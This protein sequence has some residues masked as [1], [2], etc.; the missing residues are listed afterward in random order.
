MEGKRVKTVLKILVVG[1]LVLFAGWFLSLRRSVDKDLRLPADTRVILVSQTQSSGYDLLTI[2]YSE[3]FF[4]DREG[5]QVEHTR[6]WGNVFNDYLVNHNGNICMFLH[7]ES[8]ILSENRPVKFS[9]YGE[10]GAAATNRFGPSR[11]GHIDELGLFYAVRNDVGAVGAEYRYGLRF[12]ADDG[13]ESYDV[14]VPYYIDEVC[15]APDRNALLCTVWLRS[16]ADKAPLTCIALKYDEALG[17][18]VYDDEGLFQLK[19]DFLPEEAGNYGLLVKDHFLFHLSLIWN[20]QE[21]T[22]TPMLSK[23]DL[24]TGECVLNQ[25]VCEGYSQGGYGRGG[26]RILGP[27]LPVATRNGKLYLFATNGNVYIIEDEDHIE[28]RPM[29]YTFQNAKSVTAPHSPTSLLG[30]DFGDAIFQVG[31]DGEI[32]VLILFS[33]RDMKIFRLEDGG[34]Y[35]V[36]WDGSLPLGLFSHMNISDFEIVTYE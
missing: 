23:Y 35:S 6:L 10:S 21:E 9:D 5:R 22:Y 17:R 27:N 3:L 8:A 24:N 11:V 12:V 32:Y 20:E 16:A 34:E 2:P 18:F 25:A 19:N 33:N 13:S 36:F 28:V 15:Y 26:Y 31:N 7:N 4:L 30:S 14:L 1:C 29:P